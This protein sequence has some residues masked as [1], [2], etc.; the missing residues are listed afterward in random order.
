M[1]LHGK[2]IGFAL[3]IGQLVDTR[4]LK[5]QSFLLYYFQKKKQKKRFF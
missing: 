1:T 5:E 4:I 2:K 3:T